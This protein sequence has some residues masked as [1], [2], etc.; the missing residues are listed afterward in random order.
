MN[1]EK[2][3]EHRR[4]RLQDLAI[5]CNGYASLGRMLG[6]RDGAFI[7]Q[8]AKGT[9]AISEDFVSRCEALPGF[10]G[11][12]HSYQDSGDLFTPELLHKL[13]NMPAEDRK[14]MENLLRSALNMPLIR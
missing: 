8:L 12:F 10:S 4:T 14:R 7:S 3:Q 13:K 11:W 9:R 1:K 5:A 6:Y 2:L